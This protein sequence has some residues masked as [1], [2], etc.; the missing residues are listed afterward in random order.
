MLNGYAIGLRER[1]KGK[2]KLRAGPLYENDEA[3]LWETGV[4]GGSNPTSL[5][6]TAFYLISQHFGTRGCHEH[7]QVRV[8]D[9]KVVKKSDGSGDTE[10]IEWTEGLTKT[11]QGGLTKS[12][13]QL[14]QRIFTI[15]GE[16]CAMMYLEKL[17]SKR[18]PSLRNSGPLYL[19]PLVRFTAGGDVWY[20]SQPVGVNMI[21]SFMSKMAEQAGLNTSNKRFTNHS[22]RKTTVRKLQKAGP[23]PSKITA[24]TGHKSHQSL[25]DYT[26]IICYFSY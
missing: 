5:N 14:T 9:L 15:G 11:R 22:V 13:R 10:Y 12:N 8:E 25:D 19:R 21:N 18:P 7:H 2:R 23:P 6:Y 3:Q 17:L 20:S 26:D 1:G 16:N 24:I 4:L